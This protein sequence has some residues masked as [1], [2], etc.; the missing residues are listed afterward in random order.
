MK[1]VTDTTIACS[2]FIVLFTISVVKGF[3]VQLAR[4]R[5]RETYLIVYYLAVEFKRSGV[6]CGVYVCSRGSSTE[7]RDREL[8]GD[9]NC[10]SI[11]VVHLIA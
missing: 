10:E 2:S 5:P 6:F 11:T 8:N 4:L 9:T 7:R 3:V 1:A